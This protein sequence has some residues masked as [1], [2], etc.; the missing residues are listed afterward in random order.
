MTS[1]NIVFRRFICILC[2]AQ[3]YAL[4]SAQTSFADDSWNQQ[5]CGRLDSLM[6]DSLLLSSQVGLMVWDLD[7]D[8]VVYR[9]GERQRLRPASTQKVMTAIAAID[10][11][12]GDYQF[13]TELRYTGEIVN[14]VLL[15][16][17]YCVGKFDP[18]FGEEDMRA[19]VESIRQLNVDTI[20]GHIYAD[21]SAKD[22]NLLGEGWCWDDDNPVLSP[23]L[24][25]R[26]DHFLDVFMEQLHQQGIFIDVFSGTNQCPGNALLLC[27]R[28]HTM[29]EVLLQMMKESDNLYAESMFYQLDMIASD[30][31]ATAKG[32]AEVVKSLITRLGQNANTFSIADGSGLSLY[33]YLTAELE[34]LALRYAARNEWIDIHFRP[35]LPIAGVDGTLKSRMLDT[36]AKGNVQAKTGSVTGVSSLAGYCK[37]SNGHR[38]CF[39]IINQGVRNMKAGRAFQDKVCEILCAKTK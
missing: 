26:R 13:K 33:N 20:R 16:D 12:G 7:V 23:L 35:S 27:R 15:G 3:I 28:I 22:M 24:Y 30:H 1:I 19:F 21:K 10:R 31:P 36:S 17:V 38:L 4:A 18:C 2:V 5:V 11:L 6:Q 29:D 34:V 39:S 25:L 32:A 14:N 37:A 8:T 9:Q